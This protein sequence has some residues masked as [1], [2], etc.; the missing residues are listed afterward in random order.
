MSEIMSRE[1]IAAR[2][3]RDVREMLAQGRTEVR[4]PYPPNTQPAAWW[5]LHVER[6]LAHCGAP[7]LEGS[8]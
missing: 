5:K 1:A 3:E 6:L 7:D 4:N 2:A 8:A